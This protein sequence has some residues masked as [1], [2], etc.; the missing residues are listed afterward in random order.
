MAASWPSPYR[1]TPPSQVLWRWV[2]VLG[3]AL[4]APAALPAG[5][6]ERR[7][8]EVRRRQQGR[9]EPLLNP[10]AMALHC[11]PRC[12]APVLR[13]LEPGIPLR[14]LRSWLAPNGRRWL[15]VEVAGTAGPSRGWLGG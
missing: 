13:H 7:Q 2:A 4:I 14:V 5:G 3:L 9:D 11:A 15:Q 6:G 1:P 8:P 12:Q 10:I